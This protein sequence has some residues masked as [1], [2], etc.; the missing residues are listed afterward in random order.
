M[1]QNR[2]AV[3]LLGLWAEDADTLPQPDLKSKDVDRLAPTVSLPHG[4]SP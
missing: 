2:A 4:R 3:Q 1:S